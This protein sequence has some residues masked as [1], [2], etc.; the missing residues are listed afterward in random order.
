MEDAATFFA[1]LQD[2]LNRDDLTHLMA[3]LSEFNDAVITQDEAV[4][5]ANVVL[6]HY[7]VIRAEFEAFMRVSAQG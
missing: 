5:R 2:T 4:R 1:R 6:Q 7:G 3:I